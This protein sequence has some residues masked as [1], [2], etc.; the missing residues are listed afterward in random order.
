MEE[1]KEKSYDITN[2]YGS[3]NKRYNRKSIIGGWHIILKR[4]WQ[5]WLLSPHHKMH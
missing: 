5:V 4:R 2:H 3:I 1:N